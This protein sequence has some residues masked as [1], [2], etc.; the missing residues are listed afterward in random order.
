MY[1]VETMD[2]IYNRTLECY[3]S[4][5]KHLDSNQMYRDIV[6]KVVVQYTKEN[7]ERLIVYTYINT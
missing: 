4:T 1:F 5:T 2:G 6:S 3:R 7:R